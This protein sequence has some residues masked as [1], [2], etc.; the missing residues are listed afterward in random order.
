[1]FAGRQRLPALEISRLKRDMTPRLLL[2]ALDAADWQILHPLMDAGELPT[3]NHLVEQGSVGELTGPPPVVPAIELTSVVT[4]KRAWQHGICHAAEWASD[5][6][7]LMSISAARRRSAA[8][9]QM[10]ACEGKRSL[11]IGWPATHGENGGPSCLVSDRFPEPTAGPGIKPW[12]PAVAG[13]YWPTR[14]ASILDAQRVSPED[15]G[16]GTIRG[17]VPDWRRVDQKHDRR[18]GQLRLFLAADYSYQRAALALLKQEPWDL[19]AVRFPALAPISQVF[20]G[21]HRADAAGAGQEVFQ[22][23][24]DV[25]R[26]SLHVLDEMVRQL[27]A[28][29]GPEMAVMVV[30]ALGLRPGSSAAAPSA[31]GIFLASGPGFGS[32]LLI[33]GAGVLDVTP[34]I[35]TWFGLPLGDDMEGRVLVECFASAPAI[36]RVDSWDV[37]VGMPTPAPEE[38]TSSNPAVAGVKRDSDWNFVQSCL[39]AARYT[40]ALPVLDRLFRDYPERVELSHALFQCQLALGQLTDASATLE[41]VLESLPAG[42]ASL[43]PRAELAL[44]QG[45]N[46]LARALAGEVWQLRPTHPLALRKLGILLLRLREWD[47]LAQVARQALDLNPNEA[48]AWLGLAAAQLRKGNASEAVVSATRAIQLKFFLPEAHFI[49]ARALVA[50]GHWDEAREAMETLLKLQPNNR[51]AAMYFKRLPAQSGPTGPHPN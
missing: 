16:P 23:Y 5:G 9:W 33:H 22:P 24:R 2:I 4:G 37:R 1:M 20:L 50:E 38:S 21:H 12:P 3:F 41:V 42:V 48:V 45:D 44:A 36:A 25:I 47:T 13:T 31:G 10:L 6:R 15:I 51:A 19:A 14:L 34:T 29:A 7:Q 49:R 11:V 46:H 18:V 28:A 39:D 26:A 35:L 27:I 32:D 40:E 30:S 8:L 17:Y 43:L